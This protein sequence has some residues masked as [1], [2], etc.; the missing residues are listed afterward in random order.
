MVDPE[1]G[2]LRVRSDGDPVASG[3]SIGPSTTVPP[4]AVIF[5]AAS[6]TSATMT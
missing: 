3:T 2:S 5:A 1:H 4:E 6:F